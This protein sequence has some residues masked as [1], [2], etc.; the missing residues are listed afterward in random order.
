MPDKKDYAPVKKYIFPAGVCGGEIRVFI[1]ATAS[2][3][4]VVQ[5][6]NMLMVAA[7]TWNSLNGGGVEDEPN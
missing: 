6:A 5:M 2:R 7:E 4:D 3:N 1:P